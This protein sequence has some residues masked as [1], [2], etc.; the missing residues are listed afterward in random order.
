M[1]TYI[2]IALL[3]VFSISAYG[4]RQRPLNSGRIQQPT[5]Q[6]NEKQLEERKKK[7]EE[8][9]QEYIANFMKTLEADDFQK[10]IIQQTLDSYFEKRLALYKVQ[11]KH[12][13][14]RDDAIKQLDQT[15]FAELKELISENDMKRIEEL[16]AG[17]FDDSE[18]KKKEKK[19]KRKKRKDKDK[20]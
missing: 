14:E 7:M 15:H 19:K 1:R 3:S 16:I 11:Y 18:V 5:T 4:Q 8:R 6:P 2:I 12:S 9:R 17:E 13:V 20:N 10:Q